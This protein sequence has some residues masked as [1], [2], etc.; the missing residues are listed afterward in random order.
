MVDSPSPSE[1]NFACQ[2]CGACCRESGYVYL[3]EADVDAISAYLKIGVINF[4]DRYARLTQHRHGLSLIEQDNGA[5][6]FLSEGGDCL[7]E[8]VKPLQCRQFPFVWRY[9]DTQLTC[10]GWNPNENGRP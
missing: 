6:I 4:T 1:T 5:C 10:K 2:R 9:Q 8:S 7:I 3:T